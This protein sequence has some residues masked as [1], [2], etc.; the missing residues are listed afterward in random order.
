MIGNL[1]MQ[2]EKRRLDR[3]KNIEGTSRNILSII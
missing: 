2:K 3:I 1:K